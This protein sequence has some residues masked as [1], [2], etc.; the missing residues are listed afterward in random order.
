MK[1]DLQLNQGLSKFLLG[2][3][4][5]FWP[6]YLFAFVALVGTHYVQ[7]FL[8]FLAKELADK[9][10]NVSETLATSKYY[11]LAIGIIV[12]RTSSRLLFF[13]PA[14]VMERDLRAK[15]LERLENT[16]PFRYKNF[17][18]GQ[19]YQVICQDTEQIRALIGFA[20]LQVGNIIVALAVL[21]PKLSSYNSKLVIALLPLVV[22]SLLFT[23]IV[24]RTRHY[25]RAA[26]DSQGEVQNFIMESYAG[27]STIKN[28]H[29]E[30]SFISLF[31]RYS[32][33]ELYMAY[34]AGVGV[35]FSIPLIPLGVGISLL[36]GAYIIKAQ[37]LGA[38]GLIL[39]SGFTFLFLEPLAFMSWIGI[40][41]VASAASW[42][43]MKDLVTAL[44]EPSREEIFLSEENEKLVVTS[45]NKLDFVL[46]FW[47]KN[48]ELNVFK[49]Q[50]N[51]LIGATG[52]GKSHCLTQV[53][54]ILRLQGHS[55][56]YIAQAPYLYNDTVSAN[57]F[58]GKEADGP[59]QEKA[60][61]L[62]TLFGLDYLASTRE[63]LFKL[64]VGEHGKRLS[65]GQAKRL[66]LVR[67]L[68]SDSDI[69]IWDDPFSSVDVILERQII[70]RLKKS[71]LIKNQLGENKTL[72]L[73]S[74]RLSTVKM[75]DE[76]IFLEQGKGI[77]EQGSSD[78]LL[79]G[80]SKTNG[81]FQKQ[82]L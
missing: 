16:I 33:K 74:H 32:Y 39:F 31:K 53:A 61:E 64:E 43:R 13:Y 30:E 12:F 66:C 3:I 26:Q 19:L 21:I 15:L 58:L 7:S 18:S 55:I 46:E 20:L 48:L 62:L 14:R 11:A 54:G 36:W 82:H 70:D 56:S 79:K 80:E 44:D 4:L 75:S 77:L 59:S 24:S 35:S 23:F 68:M 81:Y 51:V 57:I 1:N 60:Y 76:I 72:I 71:S 22:S 29:V 34:K 67:S 47:G 2:Q 6:Y 69:L 38:N 17:S 73:S 45:E 25:H 9:V 78:E 41:F 40:V 5:A 28:Y 50:W 8:P 37:G 10:M 52:A 27:K 42:G 49:G 65:G 63:A